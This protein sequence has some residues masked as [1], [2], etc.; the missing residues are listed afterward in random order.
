[1]AALNGKWNIITAKLCPGSM[2]PRHFIP[3]LF[4]LSLIGMPILSILWIG[5]GYSSD[6]N[7]PPIFFWMFFS[8]PRLLPHFLSFCIFYT[9]SPFSTQRMV[10]APFGDFFTSCSTKTN[11]RL[12]PENTAVL[13]F[14]D[15]FFIGRFQSIAAMKYLEHP[16]IPV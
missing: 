4:T 7:L 11:L 15:R 12:I 10:G 9:Y 16:C 2:R 6:S 5:L 13:V 14:L 3:C 1:M 8:Q